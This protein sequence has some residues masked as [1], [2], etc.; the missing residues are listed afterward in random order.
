MLFSFY[1]HCNSRIIAIL[2][3][4]KRLL[5]AIFSF[6]PILLYA[7]MAEPVNRGSVWSRPFTH[8]YVDITHEEILVTIDSIFKHA[9]FD[10]KY[11]LKAQK[12]G[13]RIPLIFYAARL[14]DTPI[15]IKVDGE[16]VSVKD[17]PEYYLSDSL[18]L[19]GFDHIM[20]TLG[21]RKMIHLAKS[22]SSGIY[23]RTNECKY[24]ETDIDKGEHLIE[25]SYTADQ[26]IDF[27]DWVTLYQ[28]QY[29]LSP[30]QYWRS[31][32][33]L[34]ITLDASKTNLPVNTNLGTPHEGDLKNIARWHFNKLPVET[35]EINHSPEVSRSAR[36]LI[37][38]GPFGIGLIIAL[39]FSIL[40]VFMLRSHRQKSPDARFSATLIF[41]SLVV[42]AVFFYVWI[43]A[44]LW[45][46]NVIGEHASSHHGYV[47]LVVIFF[48]IV[49]LFYLFVMMV[50][51]G[52]F[53]SHFTKA[54]FKSF[55]NKS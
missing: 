1:K 36:F 5:P 24:F 15:E 44:H 47:F 16:L 12:K 28:F 40:H 52:F 55:Y 35:L 21:Q 41:G 4:M 51:D 25:I 34:D 20:D 45:I 22:P 19:H 43:N 7:N 8:E 2:A 46:D 50:F 3:E 53:K 27:T 13:I 48:P 10:I 18:I 29:M 31:F 37:N 9:K 32:G 38:I 6:F 39:L 54:H 33:T 14:N 26:W 30:A 11:H 42:V 17:L 23:V 49:Y